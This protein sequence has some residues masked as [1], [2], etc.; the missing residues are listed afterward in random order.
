MLIKVVHRKELIN[1]EGEFGSSASDD[2]HESYRNGFKANGHEDLF[3]W[4]N[5]NVVRE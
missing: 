5:A 2:M 1:N 3:M 4:P